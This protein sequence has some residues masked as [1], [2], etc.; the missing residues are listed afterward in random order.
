M[1]ASEMLDLDQTMSPADQWTAEDSGNP[2][3]NFKI[4]DTIGISVEMLAAD[5]HGAVAMRRLWRPLAKLLMACERWATATCTPDRVAGTYHFT[6]CHDGR[7]A[8]S[9]QVK[10][11]E[12]HIVAMLHGVHGTGGQQGTGGQMGRGNP[13]S[14]KAPAPSPAT[15]PST[16]VSSEAAP[17]SD[18]AMLHNIIGHLA[19]RRDER[20]LTADPR[21]L[22]GHLPSMWRTK[23]VWL[24]LACLDLQEITPAHCQVDGCR[25]GAGDELGEL[26]A[27]RAS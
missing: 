23:P 1:K 20:W 24:L 13:E 27:Q 17:S 7:H 15:T 21:V 25:T 12:A 11:A 2:V 5:A 19:V 16:A 26:G 22:E 8:P 4:P 14:G 6:G 9:C 10:R 3:T 18:L